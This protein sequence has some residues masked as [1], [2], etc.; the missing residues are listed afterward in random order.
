MPFGEDDLGEVVP[1]RNV[2]VDRVACVRDVADVVD[3]ADGDR[4]VV[5]EVVFFDE[6]AFVRDIV[7]V[8]G[9]PVFGWAVF[10][11][12]FVDEYPWE[13]A[14]EESVFDE[15]TLLE[16][17]LLEETVFDE[18][19]FADVFVE[20][21]AF[22]EVA[23]LEDAL[24]EDALLEDAFPELEPVTAW[25][26]ELT[27]PLPEPPDDPSSESAKAGPANSS[28]ASRN[29][30]RSPARSARRRRRPDGRGSERVASRTT[31][32]PSTSRLRDTRYRE[33][34]QE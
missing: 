9:W 20:E 17:A 4:A 34:C 11:D 12:V 14:F 29:P 16:D 5:A 22:D 6:P 28:P 15:V 21:S 25:T 23:L 32:T 3:R 18:V 33:D 24:L 1:T 31:P 2:V 19:A 30:P 7:G 8:F 26:T 10:V 27:G 13:I